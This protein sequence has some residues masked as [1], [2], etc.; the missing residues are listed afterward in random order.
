MKENP[1]EDR[2]TPITFCREP[3]NQYLK[4]L[5]ECGDD[6]RSVAGQYAINRSHKGEWY[7]AWDA[8]D[9]RT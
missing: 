7:P 8:R 5:R 6:P 2:I 1:R 3:S 4:M 9:I